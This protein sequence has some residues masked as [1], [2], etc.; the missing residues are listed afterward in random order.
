MARGDEAWALGSRV[1]PDGKVSGRRVE[2]RPAHALVVAYDVDIWMR[3]CGRAGGG[4]CT[5]LTRY[6][7]VRMHYGDALKLYGYRKPSLRLYY[8]KQLYSVC[9][10]F[11]ILVFAACWLLYSLQRLSFPTARQSAP[12]LVPTVVATYVREI[13]STVLYG[14]LV[15]SA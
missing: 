15:I 5:V 12:T 10:V 2:R 3:G 7:T 13:P 4:T 14:F 11:S 9:R 8:K 6:C 1:G